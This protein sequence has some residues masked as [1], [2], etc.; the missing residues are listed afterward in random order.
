MLMHHLPACP[1]SAGMHEIGSPDVTMF[2]NKGFMT[3]NFT[4]YGL[5]L[6]QNR[7]GNCH[8]LVNRLRMLAEH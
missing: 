4:P 7:L 8:M 5:N 3:N 6:C 1:G 2:S